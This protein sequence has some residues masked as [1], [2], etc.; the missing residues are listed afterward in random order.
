MTIEVALVISILSVGFSIF[1]GLTNNRRNS[2]R[3]IE[4]KAKWNALIETKLDTCIAVS[5]DLRNEMKELR[6]EIKGEIR[7]TNERLVLVERKA[8][9][10]N[11]RIDEII[12]GQEK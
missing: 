4:T 3:E 10:A 1:F 11:E 2:T 9:K 12:K 8:D 5:H 7:A 6:D